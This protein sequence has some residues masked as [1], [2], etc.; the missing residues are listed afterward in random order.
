MTKIIHSQEV[1]EYENTF[2]LSD[3]FS[4]VEGTIFVIDDGHVVTMLWA[5]EY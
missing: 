5:D 4:P 2:I 1:P 3:G